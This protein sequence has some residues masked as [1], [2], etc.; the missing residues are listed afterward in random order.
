MKKLIFTILMLCT[1]GLT[2]SQW[3]SNYGSLPGDVNFS[4]AKGNAV[5]TDANG[6]SYVTGF[7]SELT[8]QNDIVTIKYTPTGDTV[9]TRSYNGTSNL[10]DEGNG[11]CVDSYGNVYV[12]GT[13]QFTGKSY[14]IVIL[15][16]SPD[17]SFRWVNQYSAVDSP[18]QDRGLAIA[19]DVDGFIYITG[20]STDIDGYNNIFT[21]KCGPEGNVIWSATEEG[22]SGKDAQGLAIAV[23]PAGNVYVTGYITATNGYTDIAIYKYS[24]EGISE[25]TRTV[26]GPA[27]S[28]DKA[29]GI[30]VDE[31]DNIYIG[32]YV[33]VSLNNT[34]CYT[35]KYNSNG[36]LLWSKTYAGGG[37]TTDKAWGIVVDTD[38]SIFISGESTDANMNTN[39]V[40]IKYS[41]AGAQLWA[42]AYNGT[43]NGDDRAEAIGIIKNSDNS[44]S[45]VV[46][47]KSW[48][49]QANYDYATV[50]YN[51]SNGVQ[52]QTSRYSF[53]GSS[54]DI[55]KDV[56]VSTNNKVF[57]T[58]F[59]QLIIDGPLAQCYISTLML[60]WGESSE[61]ITENNIPQ[62]F[63]LQQNY[64][65]PFNPSTTIKFDLSEASEVKLVVYDMLGRENTVLINQYLAAGSYTFSFTGSNL[66]SGIYFY[67]LRAGSYRDIKKMTLVK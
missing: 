47:G 13:A 59:S 4:N 51:G 67:E 53:T 9:W 63:K 22:S 25:W 49:T 14:D 29:W 55:A 8:T 10:N 54:N 23:G 43:G 7:S 44:R 6:Y 40:T 20:Y 1:F 15:K 50:R 41:A 37:G 46:T 16:Y 19:V 66:S 21:R 24:S 30:V 36:T 3:V 33:T 2:Y 52:S 57:I 18:L 12:V 34:D 31:T 61:L 11:I 38:G 45:I 60:D 27:G 58:G 35:A 65:N 62:S 64:P 48:G 26:N 32:G 42:S 28:E 5:T 39:Y 17:G 56:A